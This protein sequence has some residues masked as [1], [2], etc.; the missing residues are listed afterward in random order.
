MLL[1]VCASVQRRAALC[2]CGDSPERFIC[3]H[4]TTRPRLQIKE[5]LIY[6]AQSTYRTRLPNGETRG[7]RVQ[8]EEK[9]TLKASQQA[10]AMAQE[11]RIG[12]REKKQKCIEQ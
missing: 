3:P 2:L 9:S 10:P 11:K 6:S 5:T 7:N 12:S 4:D 1:F 8:D